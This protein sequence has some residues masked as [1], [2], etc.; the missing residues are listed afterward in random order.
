MNSVE[1]YKVCDAASYLGVSQQ[2]LRNYHARG[3]L[4]PDS[5]T[6]GGHRR[7]SKTQLDAFIVELMEESNEEN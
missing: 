2:T 3:I 6:E 1:L 7:Y 4:V 5:I